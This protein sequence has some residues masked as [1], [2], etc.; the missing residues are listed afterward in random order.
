VPRAAYSY[1]DDPAVPAFPDD[2]PII[3]F[4]G[5]C[6]LCAGWARF[7]LRHDTSRRYR[8]LTAQSAL[9]RVLYVHYGLDPGDYQ[10]NILIEEGRPWFKAEGSIRMAV[11]LGWPWRAAVVFR[12]L[13]RRL[14]DWLYDRVAGNRLRWFGTRDSCYVPVPDD[15]DRFLS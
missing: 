8:L 11:G 10:T 13:P 3:I 5:Y 7:V 4:D 15:A 1:R 2:K 6:V 12:V 14:N 9:G